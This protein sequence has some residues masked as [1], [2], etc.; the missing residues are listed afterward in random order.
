MQV[1]IPG[2]ASLG[3]VEKPYAYDGNANERRKG[4]LYRAPLSTIRLPKW[5]P[6]GPILCALVAVH[7]LG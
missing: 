3:A 5:F 1:G 6:T 4:A 2:Y 7:R